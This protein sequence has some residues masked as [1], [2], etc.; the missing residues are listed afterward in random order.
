MIGGVLTLF[1]RVSAFCLAL[2]VV[3]SAIPVYSNAA[4]SDALEYAGDTILQWMNPSNTE[5]LG[6][7]NIV[8]FGSALFQSNKDQKY[9]TTPTKSVEDSNGNVTNYYRGG[10]TTNTK[11]IDSYNRTFN[12]IHNTTN[13]TNNYSANVK[14]NDFLNT[15][16]TYNNDY[17]FS[18]D[19]QSWYYD[20][21]TS[22]YNYTSNQTYYNTDN[23]KYY[24]SIDNSTDEYYLVDVQYSP[25]FVTVNYTYNTTNN[26]VTNNYGDVTNV[27][28]YELDDGR[29]SYTLSVSEAL[30]IA[31]GYD[32]VNYELVHDDPDTLSL[33][34]FDSDYTD[35]SAY[36]RQF[37]SVNRSTSYVD[38]GNFGSALRL[39]SG[40]A[41]G[42]SIPG[43][44]AYDSL[45]IDFRAYFDDISSMSVYLGDTNLLSNISPRFWDVETT[46]TNHDFSGEKYVYPK[47]SNGFY[48][49]DYVYT[50]TT[51]I[52]STFGSNLFLDT[53]PVVGTVPTSYNSTG[54]YVES[55]LFGFGLNPST[56]SIVSSERVQGVQITGYSSPYN[57]YTA[58]N[59]KTDTYKSAYSDS[60][61]LDSNISTLTSQWVSFRIVISGGKLYYFVNGDSAGSGSFA[62]PSADKVYIASSGT[63]YLDE[64][65]VSTGSLVSTSAYTPSDSPYDTNMVL[66]LPDILA[67]NTIYVRHQIPVNGWRIGGVRPSAPTTGFFYIPLH[68]DYSGSQPQLY[69]GSNWV[70]VD[71]VVSVDGVST[72]SVI[73]FLF[74]P[75]AAAPDVNPDLQP[76]GSGSS[77]GGTGSE[78]SGSG[79]DSTDS[80]DTSALEGIFE[81]LFGLIEK[82]VGALLDGV[83]SL[84]NSLIDRLSNIVNLFGT[85]GESLSELWSW[86]PAEIV[87]VLVT[88][89]T[90]VIFFAVIKLVL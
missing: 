43:L 15:Y 82:V 19:L 83:L 12:T 28:Y 42:V 67:A 63:V 75:A 29:N 36:G 23:S 17:T 65:R 10:D 4:V 40:S 45:Q 58:Q 7:W 79:D 81:K 64:L 44:S 13:N 74:T 73:G 68:S 59:Y 89:V 86:L 38:S 6:G 80:D 14:L 37:Y 22:N 32:V 30:G 72:V 57:A 8:D 33:Q 35:S 66:A 24:L 1:R 71:A 2:V 25:T 60:I 48:D 77:S 11:I 18:T 51:T 54:Y 46:Y 90:V 61:S 39:P 47:L 16:A 70:D 34:H 56:P 49:K 5:P 85:V 88:A 87:S 31:S 27:Y 21:D 53:N 55:N 69:D 41:A 9:Y 76:G 26:S 62:C 50:G 3:A 20:N 78:D 84:A 52:E